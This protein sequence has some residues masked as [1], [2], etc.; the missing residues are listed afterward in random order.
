MLLKFWDFL[1]VEQIILTPQVKRSEIISNEYGIYELHHEL[2]NN[3]R[4]K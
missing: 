1:I 4:L 3:L 2:L